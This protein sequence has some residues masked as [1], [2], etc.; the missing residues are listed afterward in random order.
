VV[1]S[2]QLFAYHCPS[3]FTKC[4]TAGGWSRV[5][6][7]NMPVNDGI[8]VDAVAAGDMFT[9]AYRHSG[10]VYLA[11]CSEGCHLE[12]NWRGGELLRDRFMLSPTRNQ[13]FFWKNPATKLYGLGYYGQGLEVLS[14]GKTEGP[15]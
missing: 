15:F 14:G 12:D 8:A 6:L 3:D 11:Q 10:Q 2:G 1:E 9:I 4:T 5:R 7:S 13:R